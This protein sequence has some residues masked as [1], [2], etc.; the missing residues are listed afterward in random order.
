MLTIFVQNLVDRL[1]DA[2]AVEGL[3][4]HLTG[5][6]FLPLTSRKLF[7]ERAAALA[8]VIKLRSLQYGAVGSIMFWS[9]K[10]CL[11][12]LFSVESY[13]AWVR[14]YCRLLRIIIPLAIQFEVSEN[15]EMN[16]LKYSN[17]KLKPIP[18]HDVVL[19]LNGTFVAPPADEN[20]DAEGHHPE[21]MSDTV[22]RSSHLYA[23]GTDETCASRD[24]LFTKVSKRLSSKAA[25]RS[26]NSSNDWA[27]ED[28]RSISFE[29][30]AIVNRS[31]VS[32]KSNNKSTSEKS[33]S[34][35]N[36]YLER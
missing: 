5:I 1:A 32:L 3:F 35:S 23:N 28:L 27:E 14:L 26:R 19:F 29:A 30:P 31:I 16:S 9:L 10:A 17:A 20:R 13:V 36:L 25:P 34:R 33:R 6:L 15:F 22:R 21:S 7:R 4:D 18:K 2:V 8:K 24:S 11:A 12:E